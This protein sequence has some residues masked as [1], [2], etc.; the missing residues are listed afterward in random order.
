MKNVYYGSTS[1]GSEG[2]DLPDRGGLQ[3]T[4]Y[5]TVGSTSLRINCIAQSN[6]Q[7][8][9]LRINHRINK[10]GVR[11]RGPPGPGWSTGHRGQATGQLGGPASELAY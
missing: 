4:V 11:R 5:S 9:Q 7:S 1:A 6:Q 2:G 3:G 10:R 8:D